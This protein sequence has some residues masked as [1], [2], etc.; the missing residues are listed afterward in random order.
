V[1]G[2]IEALEIVAGAGEPLVRYRG[3]YR[4]LSPEA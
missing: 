4:K 2:R 3:R 1:R